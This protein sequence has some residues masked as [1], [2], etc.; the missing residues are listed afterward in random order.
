V[1]QRRAPRADDDGVGTATRGLA[2][3]AV[4]ALSAV[5]LGQPGGPLTPAQAIAGSALTVT[6][7]VQGLAVG[8]EGRLVLTVDNPLPHP[9]VVRRLAASVAGDDGCL[10]VAPWAG[11]LAVPAGGWASAE[12][13]VAVAADAGCAGRSWDLAYTAST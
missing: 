7:D 6:G 8:G 13:A 10:S 12:L 11:A 1:T 4:A 3:V 2:W 5:V 9:V